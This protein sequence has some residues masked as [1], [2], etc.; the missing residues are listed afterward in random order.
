M[1]QKSKGERK[2]IEE[3][4]EKAIVESKSEKRR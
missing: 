3:K 4:E 2:K 1:Q